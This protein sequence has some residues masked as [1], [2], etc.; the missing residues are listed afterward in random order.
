MTDKIVENSY[1]NMKDNF[2]YS[3]QI[4]KAET[5][6]QGSTVERKDI[7]K[8]SHKSKTIKKSGSATV[9]VLTNA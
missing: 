8:V 3:S 6:A 7:L 9:R 2:D 4:S 5:D 1:Q